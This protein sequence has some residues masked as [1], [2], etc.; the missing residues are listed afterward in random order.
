[1]LPMLLMKA[2]SPALM[3]PVRKIWIKKLGIFLPIAKLRLKICVP[4][5]PSIH[6]NCQPTTVLLLWFRTPLSFMR[7]NQ[8]LS[9]LTTD[10]LLAPTLTIL[11]GRMI[12]LAH[13]Q[14]LTPQ[15]L[16]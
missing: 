8:S 10:C 6:L 13:H 1:M 2:V 14:L 11:Q 12:T 9:K 5:T 3:R 7:P 15:A 4:S 16:P